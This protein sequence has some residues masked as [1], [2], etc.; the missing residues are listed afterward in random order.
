[1]TFKTPLPVHLWLW[2][3]S[4][5]TCRYSSKCVGV[6]L[7]GYITIFKHFRNETGIYRQLL[8]GV[9]YFDIRVGHNPHIQEKF[10][11]VHNIF[12]A[13][14]SISKQTN[15]WW[16]WSTSLHKIPLSNRP[17]TCYSDENNRYQTTIATRNVAF[18]CIQTYF[19]VLS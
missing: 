1:M 12:W 3:I 11:I 19:E 15:L 9:R 6:V 2:V 16:D 13:N 5:Y 8:Y 4:R 7:L 18:N 10:R 14:T 17:T